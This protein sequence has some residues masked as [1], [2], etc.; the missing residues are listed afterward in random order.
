MV[1][2][3]ILLLFNFSIF[4]HT[5]MKQ[6]LKQYIL[7]KQTKNQTNII[8][9]VKKKTGY[10]KTMFQSNVVRTNTMNITNKNE[11]K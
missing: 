5:V 3:N 8:N 4:S 1:S 10:P 11:K 2:L 6:I 7:T 9:N